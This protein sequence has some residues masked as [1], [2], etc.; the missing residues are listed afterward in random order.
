MNSIPIFLL[1]FG[2]HSSR[3]VQGKVP[4]ITFNGTYHTNLM[5]TLSDSSGSLTTTIANNPQWHK[6]VGDHTSDGIDYGYMYLVDVR[7]D[8][9]Q[10]FSSTVHDICVDMRYEFSAYLANIFRQPNGDFK[11]NARFEVRA[12]T[13]NNQLLAQLSTGEI[14]VD[15]NL[16][17]RKYGLSFHASTSSITLLIISNIDEWWEMIS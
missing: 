13:D 7:K 11:P 12:G 2:T 9:T 4:S 15:D 14:P 3:H 10:L 17:W 8:H 16:T 1:T 5:A 6:G